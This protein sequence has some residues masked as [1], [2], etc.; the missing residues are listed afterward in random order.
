VVALLKANPNLKLSIQG[1]TDSI[2]GH[3]YNVTLSQARAA[4]VV[5][6]LKTQGIA[7]ARLTSAGFGPDKPI[8]PNDTDVGRAKNR[9]V[10]LVK[11]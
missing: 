1:H 10:E 2:G 6:M 9:R 7:A 3:D 4:A 5:A 8:A 11:L